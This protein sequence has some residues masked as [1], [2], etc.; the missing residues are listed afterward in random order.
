MATA[1]EGVA[2]AVV[3][4][5]WR[6]RSGTA[7]FPD[8]VV[9]AGRRGPDDGVEAV[10]VAVAWTRLRQRERRKFWQ[11]DKVQSKSSSYGLRTRQLGF[12]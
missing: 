3:W 12:L 1:L 2:N 5:L 9:K 4:S 6:M 11:P 7:Q 8:T 10:G